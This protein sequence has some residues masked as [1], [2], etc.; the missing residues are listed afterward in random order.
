MF[1]SS[2]I[3]R[4]VFVCHSHG[5]F[6]DAN[7]FIDNFIEIIGDNGS[8][9]FPIFNWD[10][11]IGIPFDYYKT[12]SKVGALTSVA[13]KR[14]DFK[15]T[16]HPIYSFVVHFC[17]EKIGVS[18]RFLKDFTAE[19]N[20]ENGK[21]EQRTYSMYVR[22]LDVQVETTI[23]PMRAVF[24][25]N[26]T[27]TE[28][29]INDVSFN[30]LDMRKAYDLVERDIL[31]NGSG[32]ITIY[33]NQSFVTAGQ[34]MYKLAEQLFP[35][36]R[37]LTGDGVRK[38][39]SVL[40]EVVPQMTIHEVPTGTQ[41]FDWTVPKE[42]N[43]NDAFIEDMDGNRII[44]FSD[45]NLHVIG[46]SEPINKVVTRDVLL[47]MVYT[48]PDQPDVIPYVT[49]YYSE[50][51]GF[52]MSENLKQSLNKDNYHVYIDSALKDGTLTYGEIL[53][54]GQVE[55]EIF[56]STYVC[57]PS[58]ANNEV[59]GPCVAIWLAKWLFEKPQHISFRFV[60]IPET[61]GSLVY[62]SQ[63][64]DVTKNKVVAGF[65]LS[66]VGDDRAYS[67]ISS[68]YGNSLADRVVKNIMRFYAP[69]FIIYTFLQRGSDERQY[70]APGVD[71]PLCGICRSKYGEYPEY[72]TFADNL[73]LISPEGLR[74][75][76]N[77]LQK[78]ID[79]LQINKKY[80]ITCLGEPQLG[81]RGLYPTVSQ[82]GQHDAVKAMMDFIAY[83]D[84][85][86]D[87]IAISDIIDVPVD[88]LDKIARKLED[89]ELI[90]TVF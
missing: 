13:L 54:P 26:G 77:V 29:A 58:M 73:D 84:G 8:L 37:S 90:T 56:I 81:K 48:Q 75:S 4:L 78:C 61:I 83:A 31:T 21:S 23:N 44:S 39:L 57:H 16:Q 72:H 80:K 55:D 22:P 74:G 28:F 15:R 70:C 71:L 89:A 30:L 53:I 50:R 42:W 62:L 5:E 45:N 9:V 49:S 88:E 67:Y 6:F 11:C 14:K 40:R 43:I 47:E 25:E 52:C 34:Q 60:F 59:S 38:T 10:F 76:F 69:D 24:L 79:A 82:K 46:Y 36:C 35:I 33:P 68:R 86:N 85:T 12:P 1:V 87:L 18:Y 17:E 65:N 3:K 32:K 27:V 63:N 64:L 41:A 20:D 7:K 19:Y 2:D 51:S 66:C